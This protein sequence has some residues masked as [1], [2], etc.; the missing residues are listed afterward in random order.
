LQNALKSFGVMTVHGT[1]LSKTPDITS[2][3]ETSAL[4]QNDVV[5]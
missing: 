4:H 2:T 1:D 3:N 5:F